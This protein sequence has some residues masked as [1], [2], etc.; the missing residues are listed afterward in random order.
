[1]GMKIGVYSPYLDDL[2]GGERYIANLALCLA[3][4]HTVSIFWDKREDIKNLEERFS[5]DLSEIKIENNIFSSNFSFLQ[6]L[7]KTRDYDAIVFLSDG[8]IPIVLSKKLFIHIQ[9]PFQELGHSFLRSIKIKRVNSFFCNSYF[10]KYF[11]DREFGI[12]SKV[13]YPCVEIFN[14]RVP[15]ENIICTVGRFRPGKRSLQD[16]NDFKKFSVMIEAFCSMVKKGFSGWRFVVVAGVRKEDEDLFSAL[17]AKARDYPIQFLVNKSNKELWDVYNRA[18]IYWHAAGFG[19][20]LIKHPERAEHFGISTVEAMGAGAVP[21]VF[22]AGG[23]KEIVADGINGFLWDNLEELERK[24][25]T[26]AKD[27]TLWKRLSESARERAGFFSKEKF[28]QEVKSL[29]ETGK[30]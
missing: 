12:E 5:L 9:Q 15:K 24:T 4:E 21:V 14:K 28:C 19:E 7:L 23:Q 13:I 3:K 6:R 27:T 10:T 30:D 20:D 26:L 1:M 8:S 25:Y 11:V 18:K 22:G 29:I 2:G 16:L 17:Q